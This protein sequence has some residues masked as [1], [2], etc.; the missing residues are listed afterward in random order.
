LLNF[1]VNKSGR[2]IFDLEIAYGLGRFIYTVSGEEGISKN[3]WIL[4][5]GNKYLIKT[6][7]TKNEFLKET[8]SDKEIMAL[9]SD[10]MPFPRKR[11]IKYIQ[12]YLEDLL[13]KEISQLLW[14]RHFNGKY[15]EINEKLEY[16][17]LYQ[18]L[19]PSG[20]KSLTMPVIGD[21]KYSEGNTKKANKL[22]IV[23][24]TIGFDGFAYRG[25]I[26]KGDK[27]KQVT[28]FPNP[29]SVHGIRVDRHFI[30]KSE[31]KSR[32][33]KSNLGV[34]V[35]LAKALLKIHQ[36]LWMK[37]RT[38]EWED[39]YNSVNYAL[40]EPTGN[41]PKPGESGELS[42]N[43]LKELIKTDEGKH[44]FER[45]LKLINQ[46]ENYGNGELALRLSQ[47][48]FDTNLENWN[49]YAMEHIRTSLEP[50]MKISSYKENEIKEVL[51]NVK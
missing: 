16:K 19:E 39:T 8:K 32:W 30:I 42:I 15:K 20:A 7:A 5:K 25:F 43:L 10:D 45:L 47:F 24:A 33:F 48:I 21:K 36:L 50:K 3:T 35:M 9:I 27:S 23:L 13:D 11:Y 18:D 22:D 26:G 12:K 14:Q 46:N 37:K 44:I 2:P 1:Y 34:K 38:D 41:Q 17:S 40:F 51:K 49:M 6:T 4:D 31:L 29:D 28:I